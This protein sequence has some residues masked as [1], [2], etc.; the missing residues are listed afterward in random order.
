MRYTYDTHVARTL[1]ARHTCARC[2]EYMIITRV[3]SN[4]TAVERVARTYRV[5]ATH[6]T[7]VCCVKQT[8]GRRNDHAEI[9]LVLISAS[10]TDQSHAARA[11]R[12]RYVNTW[13]KFCVFDYCAHA[14]IV[15]YTHA[16]RTCNVR[17]LRYTCVARTLCE[18]AF[19]LHKVMKI[20]AGCSIWL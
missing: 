16:P 9:K 8:Q 17:I 7:R 3:S 2:V 10:V 18:R 5:R 14:S 13:L 1:H 12:V 4:S 20:L 6:G 15:R 11:C 19:T